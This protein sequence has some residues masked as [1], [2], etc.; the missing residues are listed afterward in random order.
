MSSETTPIK[1][2]SSIV[3]LRL[4]SDCCNAAE[5]A[6]IVNGGCCFFSADYV[7]MLYTYDR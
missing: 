3:V 7:C 1:L 5:S 4:F 2:T 6:I